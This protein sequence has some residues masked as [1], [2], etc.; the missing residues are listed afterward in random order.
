VRRLVVIALTLSALAGAATAAAY[1]S[2]DGDGTLSVRS[3]DGTVWMRANGAIFGR[4]DSG[5][6]RVLDPVDGDPLVVTVWGAE[7]KT[8]LN[9]TTT[10]YSGT[11]VRFRI[12]GRF[13]IKIGAEGIDLSAVG[14][15][16]IGLNGDAGTY[17]LDGKTRRALPSDPDGTLTMFDL[18]TSSSGPG[19]SG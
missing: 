13:R 5:A 1:A 16:R 17:A 18:G 15:G 4:F 11:N 7:H 3:A 19:S 12:I 8:E 10:I 14:Q 6:I 9:D 2:T